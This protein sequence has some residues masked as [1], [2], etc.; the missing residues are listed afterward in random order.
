MP[1]IDR[2]SC[3][4]LRIWGRY[5]P[6][7]RTAEFDESLG[8]PVHDALWFLSRQWQMGEFKGEDSGSAVLA[9][10]SRRLTPAGLGAGSLPDEARVEALPIEFPVTVRARLGR[11]CLAMIARVQAENPLPGPQPAIR[12][13]FLTAFAVEGPSDPAEGDW[14]EQARAT[15][16][17][18]Q[19]RTH[20]ALAG[21]AVDG[22]AV[23]EALSA[24]APVITDLPAELLARLGPGQPEAVLIG[25]TAYRDWFDRTYA[26]PGG[27]SGGPGTTSWNDAQLEYQAA[28]SAERAGGP[29]RLTVEEYVNGSLDWYS[30][31]HSPAPAA[32]VPATTTEV[33]TMIPAP[34]E[35]AGMP[36]PRWWQLEDAAVDLSSFRAQATDLAK[37][38]VA[39][40]ALIYGNNWLVVP[41]RQ[42]VGTLAEIEGVVITD[43]FGRRT[44]VPAQI[45]S[46]GGKWTAWDLFSLSPRPDAASGPPLP[47]H[48]F[49]PARAGHVLDAEP[50]ERV[51]FVRDESADLVWGIERRISDG[52]GAAQEGRDAAQRFSDA[53]AELLPPQSGDSN[54]AAAL[55]FRL[56]TGVAENWI[57]FVP[58]HE[59]SATR[60]IRLQRAAM[61]RFLPSGPQRIR[62]RTAI[63]RGAGIPYYL[64]EEEVSRA[65]VTVSGRM[66]R[67][68][69]TDG[70]T[71]VWHGRTVS[72]GRGETDSGLR[73]DV[74]EPKAE[75]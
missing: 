3:E 65:G 9:T 16:D 58:V 71:V 40:F 67:A 23:R 13:A 32:G 10:L 62:P 29:I 11:I 33:R 53:L 54:P 17:A 41:L 42:P 22:V 24:P 18:R 49:L 8:A 25:L 37:I 5:E 27:T 2:V 20:A 14:A 66:R 69:W 59:P 15:V 70:G 38:V 72:S 50:H 48:L 45:G 61:P 63:L 56:G 21:R 1:F 57:P 55:R 47:Q 75:E 46:S 73:F 51:A 30:F 43:V 52:L 4:P 34:A 19:R 74:V 39:E 7:S 68:R 44:L 26:R 36:A 28:G 12:S 35:F 6:R 60:S 64:N 31:D